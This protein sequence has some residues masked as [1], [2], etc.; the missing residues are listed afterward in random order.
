MAIYS[1]RVTR[2]EQENLESMFSPY[3]SGIRGTEQPQVISDG[4]GGTLIGTSFDLALL[5]A[6]DPEAFS[7]PALSE[8]MVSAK[9]SNDAGLNGMLGVNV[10]GIGNK[11]MLLARQRQASTWFTSLFPDLPSDLVE[12]QFAEIYSEENA[13]REQKDLYSFGVLGVGPGTTVN[14]A[15]KAGEDKNFY[16]GRGN[17]LR[18]ARLL[19]GRRDPNFFNAERNPNRSDWKP[20]L[21]AAINDIAPGSFRGMKTEEIIQDEELMDA[22]IDLA[23]Q[24]GTI[25]QDDL[26]QFNLDS[27]DEIRAR[28]EDRG[29]NQDALKVYVYEQAQQETIRNLHALVNNPKDLNPLAVLEQVKALAVTVGP[30]FLDEAMGSVQQQGNWADTAWDRLPEDTRKSLEFAGYRRD[31]FLRD[32]DGEVLPYMQNEYKYSAEAMRVVSELAATNSREMVFE[33]GWHDGWSTITRRFSD[34]IK[35]DVVNDPFAMYFLIPSVVGGVGASM[36]T[37]AV[38]SA[39]AATT[40]TS[41][42]RVMSMTALDGL[43]AGLAEGYAVGIAGQSQAVVGGLQEELDWNGVTNNMLL[44][45]G[46]GAIGGAGLAGL[47]G[48]IGPS[49]RGLGRLST[50]VTNLAEDIAATGIVGEAPMSR[51]L[52]RLAERE[53]T[54]AEVEGAQ[55]FS[56]I[57]NRGLAIRLNRG[58]VEAKEAIAEVIPNMVVVP[59]GASHSTL[60]DSLFSSHVLAENGLSPAAAVNLVYGIQRRLGAGGQIAAEEFDQV[61]RAA[62]RASKEHAA[63]FGADL[64]DDSGKLLR[65][66]TDARIQ[67]ID[68]AVTANMKEIEARF[69]GGSGLRPLTDAQHTELKTLVQ[70][71]KDGTITPKNLKRLTDYAQSLHDEKL[72]KSVQRLINEKGNLPAEELAIFNRKIDSI[73]ETGTKARSED[74]FL[75]QVLRVENALNL[76]RN[77]S[78]IKA[79]QELGIS[80]KRL[81]QYASRY[82][83]IVGDS[84]A[85]KALDAEMPDARA[86]IQAISKGEGMRVLDSTPPAFNVENFLQTSNAVAAIRE[87]KDLRKKLRSLTKRAAKL[88]EKRGDE[89]ALRRLEKVATRMQKRFMEV[90]KK[91]GIDF[92]AEEAYARVLERIKSDIPFSARTGLEQDEILGAAIDKLI[93]RSSPDAVSVGEGSRSRA[94]FNSMFRETTIGARMERLMASVSLW[95]IA[96]NRLFRHRN[97]IVRGMSNWITG[98][99]V[100]NRIFSNSTDFMSIES[101]VEGAA[102]EAV[103]FLNLSKSLRRKLGEQPYSLFDTFFL[104]QRQ[105]G[106]LVGKPGEFDLA[107]VPEA[108]LRAYENLGGEEALRADLYAAQRAYTNVMAMAIEEAAEA[109]SPLTGVSATRYIPHHIRGGLSA[110]RASKFIDNFTKIRRQQLLRG[111][112]ALDLEVLESIGW[113]RITKGSEHDALGRRLVNKKFDVPQDSPLH[114]SDDIDVNREFAEMI[115]K[116]GFAGLEELDPEAAT[117]ASGRA[118]A[119]SSDVNYAMDLI[120]DPANMAD[121]MRVADE[122]GEIFGNSMSLPLGRS[123]ESTGAESAVARSVLGLDE[124]VKRLENAR[125]TLARVSDDVAEEIEATMGLSVQAL[126]DDI[127]DALVMR[128]RALARA[129]EV[130][131]SDTAPRVRRKPMNANQKIKYVNDRDAFDGLSEGHAALSHRLDALVAEG[132]LDETAAKLVRLAFVDIDPHKMGGM[133]FTRMD[134]SDMANRFLGIAEEDGIIR[135]RKLTELA[136]EG[137]D[138]AVNAAVTLVH[139]TSHIAFLS[140]SPR[141]QGVI[142]SLYNQAKN[143]QNSI[144]RLFEQIGVDAEYA[145]SNVHEFT[146]ALAEATMLR[147][148][149]VTARRGTLGTFLSKFGKFYKKLFGDVALLGDEAAGMGEQIMGKE[150]WSGLKQIIRAIYDSQPDEAA[151]D[152]IMRLFGVDVAEEIDAYQ[153]V[154]LDSLGKAGKD[155]LIPIFHA[156]SW[157]GDTPLAPF[158]HF[159]TQQAA[160]DRMTQLAALGGRDTV[161]QRGLPA[162]ARIIEVPDVD[163]DHSTAG[164]IWDVLVANKNFENFVRETGQSWDYVIKRVDEILDNEDALIK[165]NIQEA[166]SIFSQPKEELSALLKELGIDALSYRNM[167]EGGGDLSY[168]V[169]NENIL[170]KPGRAGQLAPDEKLAFL[171]RKADKAEEK[172]KKTEANPRATAMDKQRAQKQFDEA[173]TELTD[174]MTSM[175]AKPKAQETAMSRAEEISTKVFARV[176]GLSEERALKP[177]Q[178]D[179]VAGILQQLSEEEGQLIR[180]TPGRGIKSTFDDMDDDQIVDLLITKAL[181]EAK[182]AKRAN[183]EVFDRAKRGVSGED[184]EGKSFI[185]QAPAAKTTTPEEE[186]IAREEADLFSR[187]LTEA[188]L[189]KD[190][191]IKKAVKII[192]QAKTLREAFER[193]GLQPNNAGVYPLTKDIIDAVVDETGIAKTNVKVHNSERGPLNRAKLKKAKNTVMSF[194]G[195]KEQVAAQAIDTAVEKAR[196]KIQRRIADNEIADSDAVQ[197]AVAETSVGNK[198]DLTGEPIT[199]YQNAPDTEFLGVPGYTRLSQ[200]ELDEIIDSSDSVL[201]FMSRNS[202]WDQPNPGEGVTFSREAAE[203]FYK[204]KAQ[205]AAEPEAPTSKVGGEGEPPSKPPKTKKGPGEEP[206]KP[207][208]PTKLEQETEDYLNRRKISKIE[209]GKFNKNHRLTSTGKSLAKLYAD[210]VNGDTGLLSPAFKAMLE[211]EGSAPVSALER[212]G[213][214][215][216]DHAG[217]R[218]KTSFSNATESIDERIGVLGNIGN[219]H[220]RTFNDMD[221]DIEGGEALA[222]LFAEATN[223]AEGLM[224]YADTTLASIRVQKGINQLTGEK[225]V[226]MSDMFNHMQRSLERNLMRD[227]NG[228]PRTLTKQQTDEVNEWMQ[229]MKEI[230]LRARGFNPAKDKS[231]SQGSRIIQNLSYSMLGAKFAMSVLFVETPL[232]VLRTSGLNPLKMVH[233]TSQILGAYLRAAQGFAVQFKP[234]ERFMASMG[235]D[236]RIIRESVDDMVFSFSNLHST[237]LSRFGAGGEGLEESRLLFTL[238]DRM[239]AH[240]ENM[241]AA[242]QADALDP[243]FTRKLVNYIEALTGATADLTG[244][245][246]FMHPVTNAVR[247]IGSN[248]AKATLMKHSGALVDLAK[249]VGAEGEITTE[250]IVGIARELGIP[251]QL[252]VYAAESG[253]LRRDGA[254][255]KRLMDLGGFTPTTAGR[256]INMN[257]LRVLID[258]ERTNLMETAMGGTLQ[259]AGSRQAEI[260]AEILPSLNQFIMYFT[261]ELSPE[262]R[263]TMRFQ[264]MNPW[265]DLLFQMLSYPMAAYQALVGNGITARGPL[266]TAGVL[267]T[268]VAMEYF[269]RNAQRVLFGKEEEDRQKALEKLTRI[270]TEEDVVEMLAMYGT[271]SPIFGAFGSYVRDLAGNPIMR[272]YG[273]SERS[274]PATPF[275]SPAIG[276]AQKLY[277]QVSRGVGSMG[278]AYR[279]G[280]ASKMG[281]AAGNLLET[282]IDLSPLNALP[283]GQTVRA[284]KNLVNVGDLWKAT[285]V[286]L[287]VG[288]AKNAKGFSYPPMEDAS[289]MKWFDADESPH[290]LSEV[291]MPPLPAMPARSTTPQPQQPKQD[292]VPRMLDR[293]DR[294]PSS[295]LANLLR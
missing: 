158:T 223:S 180:T 207:R 36:A 244:T 80:A 255:I 202:E 7:T 281:T 6:K 186:A 83:A 90:N 171:K 15:G 169:V 17:I 104:R 246:S 136:G 39:G 216:L 108:L 53:A 144:R 115:I 198:G 66:A 168:M 268:L 34:T 149:V 141:M 41:L 79:A 254:L 212:V 133:S 84:T 129:A 239:K 135:L 162:R 251:K 78:T 163:G 1:N 237:A 249:R 271:S 259:T 131:L 111:G 10:A 241:R 182:A 161:S 286:G 189:S 47:V 142:Q 175:T 152:R 107:G 73:V 145:M 289:Y 273:A 25:N 275:R 295:G 87:A 113:I 218:F 20:A 106:R 248:Q 240:A 56:N 140:A 101:I 97:R 278:T 190:K 155:E 172:L 194:S 121:V 13:K 98:Q 138:R 89:K 178:I 12:A 18:T 252:A 195:E 232:A 59:E 45:G 94:W 8:Q 120:D 124:T 42:G 49:I 103:P 197:Q 110:E 86:A 35:T 143:G 293:E 266:M 69:V 24:T 229:G 150:N 37:G 114:I 204:R 256:D 61:V 74:S 77:E 32:K 76:L 125:S 199:P 75:K 166:K 276:M 253:L 14:E 72:M 174:H 4:R 127:D 209:R 210:A 265:T 213:R 154:D 277:G 102:R 262:L 31:T 40:T 217:G 82:K 156:G 44:Y 95:P 118:A 68:A 263:G 147:N 231:F 206:E 52:S 167:A 203:Y 27:F 70:A 267:T 116:R 123:A 242:G 183:R 81:M 46:M 224:R 292:S 214:H 55:I 148:Q 153:M 287:T 43:T 270:P 93:L 130:N 257:D 50:H 112:A 236:T 247:E 63:K 294:G 38:F 48:G 173:V 16:E 134:I 26:K 208:K 85:I 235:M 164:E 122:V 283:L 222:D 226:S 91:L 170:T 261:N 11:Q 284:A 151:S 157:Q 176:E 245:M 191:E 285:H 22:A 192:E 196:P 100:S 282:A 159:G 274:F 146:A 179:A 185:E 211:A 33:K 128:Q 60:A 30:D 165:S 99:H 177:Y 228:I 28:G 205:K 290:G 88:A 96:Q 160:K 269:N 291:Q 264:G 221:F 279:E 137:N 181:S 219:F 233:N 280:D 201:A 62:F 109:G 57:E 188:R 71:L 243:S 260:D 65:D 9:A 225:G 193:R 126:K 132:F 67:Q 21:V 3:R 234:L 19:A 238:K 54:V 58:E 105:L 29:L 227:D 51:A 220:N 23:R 200:E 5:Q 187:K 117:P 250:G 258:T 139:E 215:Y 64:Y 230:Y 2:E 184:A 288:S 272:A 92:D 119:V